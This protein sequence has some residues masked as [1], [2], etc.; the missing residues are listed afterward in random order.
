MSA[1]PMMPV[2]NGV[3]RA[4]I[5]SKEE[6]SNYLAFLETKEPSYP[7]PNQDKPKNYPVFVRSTY[8]LIGLSALPGVSSRGYLHQ[9]FTEKEMIFF[10]LNV[11]D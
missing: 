7:S 5:R 9:F 1:F 3:Y 10:Q 6:W 8:G 2:E 4:V 11:C